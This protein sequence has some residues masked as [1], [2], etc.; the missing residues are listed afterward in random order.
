MIEPSLSIH[1]D[2]PCFLVGDEIQVS[3]A[4]ELFKADNGCIAPAEQYMELLQARYPNIETMRE[5]AQQKIDEYGFNDQADSNSYSV[6][7]LVAM[8]V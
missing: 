3:Q 1:N 4:P 8:T 5:H 2:T 7:L 6:W